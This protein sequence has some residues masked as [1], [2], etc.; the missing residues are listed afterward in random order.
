M[1]LCKSEQKSVV[2]TKQ[3]L[4]VKCNCTLRQIEVGRGIKC[5]SMLDK[6]FGK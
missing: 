2:L 1:I 5:E 6:G 4:D 3:L